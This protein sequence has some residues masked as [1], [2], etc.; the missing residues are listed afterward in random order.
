MKKMAVIMMILGM[1]L[2]FALMA[3]GGV[4]G[5]KHDFATGTSGFSGTFSGDNQEVCVYCHT[6]HG[7][8]GQ[9]T[10][11][12]NK[13]LNTTATYQMYSS[14][15]ID[16]TVPSIPSAYSLMCLSCHDGVSAINATRNSP[17]PGNPGITAN[18]YDQFIDMGFPAYGGVVNIGDTKAV[19]DPIDLTND[20]P[21]SIDYN[22]TL[23]NKDGGLYPQPQDSRL[24]LYNGKVECPTCHDPHNGSQWAPGEVTFMR[25]SN[26]GSAMCLSCHIK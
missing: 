20:H 13:N 10:P 17:G 11:L 25:M 3:E 22:S 7:A 23:V 16:A 6:P 26:A 9:Q 15:T 21:I 14:S 2:Y 19:G 18:G 8:L 4:V 5:S 24:K 12:W 1:V